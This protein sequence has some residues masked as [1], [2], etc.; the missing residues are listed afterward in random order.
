METDLTADRHEWERPGAVEVGTGVHRIPLPL[1][2]D[3]LKAVNVY[4]IADGDEVVLVDGGWALAES[5]RELTRGLAT[6][7]YGLDQVREFLC[8][9]VHRDHYTQAVAVRRLHGSRVSLGEGERSCLE[10]IRTVTDH[11]DIARLREAGATELAATLADRHGGFDQTNWEDPDR[12]LS[13]GVE[14]PLRTRT[15]RA[16]ATPGHTRGHL[17]FHDAAAASLFA[18]DHVLPHITPSIGVELDRPPSPLRDYLSSLE[19]VRALPDARLLPAHGPA[20]DSVHARIDELLAHHERRLDETVAAV[21]HGADT[22]YEAARRLGWTRRNR[23][24]DDLDVVNRI[25]AV[26]ETMAHLLVLVERGR[27][28]SQPDETGTIRF[29]AS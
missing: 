12:W 22:G 16:I 17:V 10:L 15:L 29:A 4:A 7:G 3:G 5:E 23:H 8:T 24:F 28:H 20:T 2:N 25:L 13:D 27:L 18:G 21:D 14:I 6:L 1:P 19:L 9:H 11:P 26:Q